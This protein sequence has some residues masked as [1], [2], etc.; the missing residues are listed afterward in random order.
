MGSNIPE[1]DSK[2][3]RS[4]GHNLGAKAQRPCHRGLVGIVGLFS[5][6]SVWPRWGSRSLG[7][8][9]M[10]SNCLCEA[11]SRVSGLP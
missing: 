3:K 8:G 2:G 7:L 6:V 1:G 11:P 4:K 10:G 9:S 5:G